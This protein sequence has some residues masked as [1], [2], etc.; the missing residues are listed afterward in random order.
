M[1]EAK[2]NRTVSWRQREH[3]FTVVVDKSQFVGHRV[4]H[5]F[6]TANCL[7]KRDDDDHIIVDGQGGRA[8]SRNQVNRLVI[9]CIKIQFVRDLDPKRAQDPPVA[10]AQNERTTAVLELRQHFDAERV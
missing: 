2:Q 7:F 9:H 4:E 10:V 5:I 6:R 3:T 1:Y 8:D